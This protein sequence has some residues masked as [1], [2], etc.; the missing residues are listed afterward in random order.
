M[1]R[2][3]CRDLYLEV[4]RLERSVVELEEEIIELKMQLKRKTEEATSLSIENANLRHK[5]E[6]LERREKALIDLLKSLKL[7][8]VVVDEDRFEDV[9]IDLRSDM[10][11]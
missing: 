4:E 11:E 1:K 6:L 7:P 8:L 2:W 3:L 10:G 5:V 9:E